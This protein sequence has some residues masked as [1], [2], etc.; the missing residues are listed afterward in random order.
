MLGYVNGTY[1]REYAGEEILF[2]FLGSDIHEYPYYLLSS[3]EIVEN[4][5]QAKAYYSDYIDRKYDEVEI[6]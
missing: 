6:D 2:Y 3:K 1:W 5:D 4:Q